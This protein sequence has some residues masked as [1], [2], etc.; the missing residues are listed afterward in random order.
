MRW[1]EAY[2]YAAWL[3]GRLP[4]EAEWEYAARAGVVADT[5]WFFGDDQSRLGE[6]AWFGR[7]SGVQAVEEKSPNPLGFH[8]MYGNVQEW[9]SDWYESYPADLEEAPWGPPATISGGRV[10]RGGTFI[11]VAV[12]ARS[13]NRGRGGP[14][15][16]YDY[17]GFRVVLPAPC[18]D[19]TVD[20]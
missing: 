9:V 10:I 8:D 20:P 15:Y 3:G 4:T 19:S 11:N 14:G 16:R 7:V 12:N 2:A 13:A 5:G 6:Y 17:L 18:R 1:Y